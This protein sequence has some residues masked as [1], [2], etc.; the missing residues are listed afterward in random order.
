[1]VN[2]QGLIDLALIGGIKSESLPNIKGEVGYAGNLGMITADVT[3]IS[4]A[5]KKGQVTTASPTGDY[6]SSFALA[7]DA[8]GSSSSYQDNAPV[9][10][11]AVQYPYCIVVNTGVEEPDRPINNYQVNNVYSYGMSKYYKGTM[12]NNSWLKSAGQ[13]NDGTVY[14]GMYNWLLEQMNNGVSGFVA[15]TATYTDYDF[16]INTANQT[17]RL[18][19]LDTRILVEK[20]EPTDADQHWYNLYSDGWLEQGGVLETS[21]ATTVTFVKPYI[22]TPNVM[23]TAKSLSTTSLVASF[24]VT[25]GGWENEGIFTLAGGSVPKVWSAQGYTNIPQNTAWNLYYYIGDTLQNAQLINVARIEETLI[26]KAD[27]DASNFTTAGKQTIVGWGMPDYSA[28]VAL[29]MPY[30]APCNGYALFSQQS[31]IASEIKID[32]VFVGST[33]GGAGALF[34]LIRPI[35]KDQQITSSNNAGIQ[36]SIFF[37]LKGVN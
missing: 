34:Y 9:Q 5:F 23:V 24:Y 21:Q 28:G 3:L 33:G 26:D 30:T 37:P 35:C 19:L 13:W 10:Q 2:A 11:E 12:N 16:V 1:M 36:G 20:K 25:S 29:T 7:F 32:G 15:S 27:T 22:T 4:G 17:F 18:P 8:S 6:K 14:T 31:N